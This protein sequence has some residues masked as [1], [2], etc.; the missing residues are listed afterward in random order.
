[1]QALQSLLPRG[2]VWPR[3]PDATQTQTL[4]GLTQA[5]AR[6]SA[7]ANDLLSESNPATT[8]ELLPEWESTL[9]LPDPEIGQLPTI[10]SRRAAVVSKISNSGGQSAAYFINQAA[11]LGY[12]ITINNNAPFRVGQSNVGQPLGLTDWF[13]TWSINTPSNAIHRFSVGQSAVG[14][15]LNYWSNLLLATEMNEISPAHTIL[16]FNYQ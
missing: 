6:L 5:N 11:Q 2:A 12:S 4:L 9:G 13:F 3:D 10:Q 14:E 7:R 15:P 16:N 8:V 1:M